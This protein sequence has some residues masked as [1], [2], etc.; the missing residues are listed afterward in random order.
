MR[1]GKKI[2]KQTLNMPK[3]IHLAIRINAEELLTKPDTI[4]QRMSLKIFQR[5]EQCI[6]ELLNTRVAYDDD[7]GTRIGV[8]ESFDDGHAI[9][10]DGGR[11]VKVAAKQLQLL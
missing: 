4:M 6:R 8:V 2:M 7:T 1:A 5:R 11:L 9:I 10:R 3:A